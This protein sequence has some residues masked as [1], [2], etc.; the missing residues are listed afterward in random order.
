MNGKVL[1]AG[2]LKRGSSGAG[3]T[4]EVEA[5]LAANCRLSRAPCHAA[6][7]SE[8]RVEGL[9]VRPQNQSHQAPA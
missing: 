6:S 7:S 1:Q 4:P 8:V 3:A 2:A 5:A 9:L